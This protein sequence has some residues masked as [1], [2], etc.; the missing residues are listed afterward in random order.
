MSRKIIQGMSPGSTISLW[1]FHPSQPM[2]GDF[3][4]RIFFQPQKGSEVICLFRT[5]QLQVLWTR[6]SLFFF[7]FV[8]S[9]QDGST[10]IFF[11]SSRGWVW[12]SRVCVRFPQRIPEPSGSLSGRDG[13]WLQV[14]PWLP[15]RRAHHLSGWRTMGQNADTLYTYEFKILFEKYFLKN[16]FCK[17]V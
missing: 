17:W 10:Y 16:Y 8:N 2:P 11:I 7:F 12:W 13:Y 15:W 14:W 4:S 3:P 6:L 1:L 9:T 5:C